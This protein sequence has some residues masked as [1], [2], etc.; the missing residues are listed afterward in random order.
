MKSCCLDLACREADQGRTSHV[1]TPCITLFCTS[2]VEA[3]PTGLY[4]FGKCGVDG[5]V[6]SDATSLLVHFTKLR[7]G[8]MRENK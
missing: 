8:E 5:I 3:G 7:H 2:K 4:H 1:P 6:Y